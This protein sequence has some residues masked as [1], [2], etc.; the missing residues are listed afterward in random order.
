MCARKFKVDSYLISYVNDRFCSY[1][2][3]FAGRSVILPQCREPQVSS[4]SPHSY[5]GP[6]T[7]SWLRWIFVECSPRVY[8]KSRNS[9]NSVLIAFLSRVFLKA[10]VRLTVMHLF[11][12]SSRS[13]TLS[14]PCPGLAVVR[15]WSFT[16]SFAVHVAGR[17][18]SRGIDMVLPDL[19]GTRNTC[20]TVNY[21]GPRPIYCNIYFG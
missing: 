7:T 11:R 6:R 21:C 16:P 13:G 12:A 20:M 3:F 17:P 9:M 10:T 4:Q 19:D 18:S 2:T 15:K 5:H 14:V 8:L 1:F